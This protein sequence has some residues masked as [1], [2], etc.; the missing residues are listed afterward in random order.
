METQETTSD[1]WIDD[2]IAY[3]EGGPAP[4]IYRKWGAIAAVAGV[5]ERKVHVETYDEEYYAGM[6]TILL[7]PPGAGKSFIIK[8]IEKL[9]MS[10]SDLHVSS[11]DT[12]SAAMIDQLNLAKRN[13]I[14]P[15]QR[16]LE[17]NCLL[18]AETELSTLFPAYDSGFMGLLTDIWDAGPFAQS[19]RGKGSGAGEKID[20]PKPQLQMISGTTPG[21]FARFLPDSAWDQGFLARNIIVFTM[22]ETVTSAFRK[23]PNKTAM[24]EK[25]VKGL[26]RISKLIGHMT[27]SEEALAFGDNFAFNG[28]QPAPN[29]PKLQFYKI[30]RQAHLIKLSMVIAAAR[31]SLE[32]TLFDI[33]LAFNTLVE[34]ETSMEDIFRAMKGGGSVAAFEEAYHT[35]W[36]L[37]RKDGKPVA[38]TILVQSLINRMP[39]Y[40]IESAI[41]VMIQSGWIRLVCESGKPNMYLPLKKE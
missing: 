40:S 16:V 24:W 25:L 32:I 41:K 30:R 3:T 23:T 26:T 39:H 4:L 19:R 21:W 34:V 28:G 11:K 17:F 22:E 37:Y 5:L 36:V 9:W 12:T 33:Q 13:I 2:F 8:I 18:I 10:I 31:G 27:F 29:H 14:L 20:I 6:Y 35:L 7:G 15:S 38:E 1:S